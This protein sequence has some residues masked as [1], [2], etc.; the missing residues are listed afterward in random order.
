[1]YTFINRY[2]FLDRLLLNYYNLNEKQLIADLD[3]IHS[4]LNK[5]SFNTLE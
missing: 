4:S 1:M 5:V 3:I 2:S